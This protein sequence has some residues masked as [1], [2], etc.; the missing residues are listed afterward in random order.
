VSLFH[1]HASPITKLYRSASLRHGF[2]IGSLSR[3]KSDLLLVQALPQS[4][5]SHL[6]TVSTVRGS[7]WVA[8]RKCEI[9]IDYEYDRFTH[10]LPRTVLTVSKC[11]VLTFEARRWCNC[12]GGTP[13]PPVLR[14]VP[15]F[16]SRA[17]TGVPPLQL[18]CL[19]TKKR[20]KL[21]IQIV[22]LKAP[23]LRLQFA[24]SNSEDSVDVICRMRL[25]TRYSRVVVG[26]LTEEP[27]NRT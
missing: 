22:N 17:A 21:E 8:V 4:P 24:T 15:L 1:L 20:Q 3:P 6:E 12:R 2:V 14:I 7:G 19:W 9:A 16:E 26:K 23:G 13:W 27:P 18:H 5:K 25:R 11:D 10:P